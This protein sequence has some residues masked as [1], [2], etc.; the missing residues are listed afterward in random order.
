MHKFPKIINKKFKRYNKLEK[1]FLVYLIMLFLFELLLPFISI[2]SVNYSFLSF[3]FKF[4]SIILLFTLLLI[5]LWNF[6]YTFKWII[7]EI[8]WFNYN[9]SI[10]N[11]GIL[12]LHASLLINTKWFILI[13]ARTQSAQLYKLSYGFYL[14]GFLLIVWLIWT[15][16]L[17]VNNS[18][19]DKKKSNYLKI[20]SNNNMENNSVGDD[21]VKTL[22]EDRE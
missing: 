11:F 20:V 16:F 9:E 1:I 10:L 13:L 3:E 14:I 22:F 15:L 7:K 19:F 6:S 17:A 8:F 5:I 18:I 21:Q 4:T 2:E 12:F